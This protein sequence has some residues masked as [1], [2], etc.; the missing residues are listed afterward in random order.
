MM[1]LMK[2]I[3]MIP[4]FI[5]KAVLSKYVEHCYNLYKVAFWQKRLQ[6][7][8]TDKNLLYSLITN[9]INENNSGNKLKPSITNPEASVNYSKKYLVRHDLCDPE[10]SIWK[11]NSFE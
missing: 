10:Y 6:V 2:K 4:K 8:D 5:Q 1:S 7:R 11:I 3:L 9:Q